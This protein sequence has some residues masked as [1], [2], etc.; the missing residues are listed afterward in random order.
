MFEFAVFT[1]SALSGISPSRGE[2]ELG[3][4]GRLPLLSV[5]ETRSGRP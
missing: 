4:R 1:P 2:M 5:G 3:M